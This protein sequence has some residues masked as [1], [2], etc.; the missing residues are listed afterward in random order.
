MDITKTHDWILESI[1]I[2]INK[3]KICLF[4][5]G[6]TGEDAEFTVTK[7]TNYCG[8][9]EAPWGRSKYTYI[10]GVEIVDG[11][12]KELHIELQTGDIIKID[13]T[14]EILSNKEPRP[15][16]LSG[17][18]DA[19]RRMAVQSI[20]PIGKRPEGTYAAEKRL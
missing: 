14:G 13:Y 16:A 1:Q 3:N 18:D 10:N 12:K 6:Y 15:E 9:N 8:S 19:H 4:L 5:S 2:D 17:M 7:I 11:N 20:L